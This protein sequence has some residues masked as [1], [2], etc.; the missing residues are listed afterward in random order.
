MRSIVAGGFGDNVKTLFVPLV[1]TLVIECA[2]QTPFDLIAI[3]DL[4]VRWFSFITVMLFDAIEAKLK[5]CSYVGSQ[6]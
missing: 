5:L 4:F 2:V 1:A 3:S 6:N